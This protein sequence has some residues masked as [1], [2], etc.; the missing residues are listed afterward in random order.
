MKATALYVAKRALIDRLART[1]EVSSH[2]LN[3]WQVDYM[4]PGNIAERAIYGGSGRSTQVAGD[5]EA[6]LRREDLTMGLYVRR[7]GIV[8]SARE[9][10]AEVE[11]AADQVVTLLADDPELAGDLSFAEVLATIADVYAHH[12][13]IEVILGLSIRLDAW[14]G[15]D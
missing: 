9:I 8:D 12:E 10:E 6:Q 3:G 14:L 7:L 11:A 2:P 13:Q 4:R 1:V 5:A 15:L